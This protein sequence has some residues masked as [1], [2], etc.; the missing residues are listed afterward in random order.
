MKKNL[1]LFILFILGS[2]FSQAQQITLFDSDGVAR[3]F[4]DYDDDQTI[5]LWD[6]TPIAF[7]EKEGKEICVIGLNGEFLGWY[8]QGIL[9]DENGYM[10]GIKKGAIKMETKPEKMKASP[11]LSPIHPIAPIAPLQ[12][13]L[14]DSWSNVNLADFLK[15]GK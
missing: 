8:Q 1:L 5:F 2:T 9:Y 6:G 4:I 13:D 15:L 11:Q 14:R 7:L 3:A 10:V 12:P